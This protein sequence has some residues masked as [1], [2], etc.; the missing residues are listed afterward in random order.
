MNRNGLLTFLSVGWI[1]LLLLLSV[2]LQAAPDDGEAV[3]LN[4]QV[5]NNGFEMNEANFDQ[6]VF[7]N[8]GKAKQA[9]EKINVRLKLQLDEL[10]RICQLTDTQKQK[11]TLAASSDIKR[12]F[13]FI[14]IPIV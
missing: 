8:N 14:L 13:D 2:G 4:E 3:K 9:R 5:V 12:F 11:L 7:Q 10:N 1:S 6:W